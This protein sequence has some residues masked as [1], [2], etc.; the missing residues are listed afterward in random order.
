MV[1]TRGTPQTQDG[2]RTV[3]YMTTEGL[4]YLASEYADFLAWEIALTA[5][6]YTLEE[7]LRPPVGKDLEIWRIWAETGFGTIRLFTVSPGGVATLLSDNVVST[8]YLWT[9]NPAMVYERGHIAVTTVGALTAPATVHVLGL[10][11]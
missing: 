8:L 3:D 6:V 5:R 4:G 9:A 2:R 7:V 1:R 11:S 10:V